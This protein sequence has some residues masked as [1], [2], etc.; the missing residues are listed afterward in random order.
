MM[1]QNMTAHLKILPTPKIASQES[2]IQD[3]A[4]GAALKQM[5]GSHFL[6]SRR[7]VYEQYDRHVMADTVIECGSDA[8]LVRVHGTDRGLAVTTDCTQRYVLADPYLGAM[9]AVAE[10]YRNITA[11]GAKTISTTNNLNFGNPETGYYGSDCGF[12]ER[13]GRSLYCS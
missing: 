10:A 8:G 3:T 7:W 5:M 12:G 11:T 13:H 2:F 9:Q 1:H 4:L 6:A